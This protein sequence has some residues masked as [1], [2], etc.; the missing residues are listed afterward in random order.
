[1]AASNTGT[2]QWAETLSN[3]NYNSDGSYR[4]W[5]LFKTDKPGTYEVR[6]VDIYD[7]FDPR[8]TGDPYGRQRKYGLF[9]YMWMAAAV[10]AA[11]VIVQALL[12]LVIMILTLGYLVLSLIAVGLLSCAIMGG[13]GQLVLGNWY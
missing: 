5:N 13:L 9:F 11:V 1:M 7:Y 2:E 10:V 6:H 3:I 4:Q 12:F 8:Y